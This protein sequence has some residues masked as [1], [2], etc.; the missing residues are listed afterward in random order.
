MQIS[1]CICPQ[2]S[3]KRHFVFG[4]DYYVCEMYEAKN[5]F[6]ITAQN[7]LTLLSE[8]GYLILVKAFSDDLSWTVQRKQR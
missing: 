1:H 2:I 3:Q 7:D 6:G 8:Q 5:M 4:K